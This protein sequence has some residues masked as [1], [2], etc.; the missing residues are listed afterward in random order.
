MPRARKREP[1]R[2][3]SSLLPWLGVGALAFILFE[4]Q[5]GPRD[6]AQPGSPQPLYGGVKYLFLVRLETTE[7]EAREKLEVKGIENL[8]FTRALNPPFWVQQGLPY[9]PVVASFM[10]TPSGNSQLTLGSDF[11]GVGKLERLV[12]LDGMPFSTPPA[13]A[14]MV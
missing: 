6:V 4:S 7:A 8:Q 9:S 14:E 10:S 11:Y 3:L 1:E 2:D 12:R 5:R 13:T